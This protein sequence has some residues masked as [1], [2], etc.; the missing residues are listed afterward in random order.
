MKTIALLSLFLSQILISAA[1]SKTEVYIPV[2]VNLRESLS[3]TIQYV[4]P[5]FL[6]GMVYLNDGTSSNAFL[7]YNILLD[8]MHFIFKDESTGEDRILALANPQSINFVSFGKRLL[9]HDKKYGYLEVLMN[10]NIKLLKKRKLEV[11]STDQPKDSYGNLSEAAAT[12]TMTS[13]NGENFHYSPESEKLI[14]ANAIKIEKFYSLKSKIIKPIKSK[15]SLLK[16][17]SKKNKELNNFFDGLT[18]KWNEEQNLIEY[19]K[20]VNKLQ[21][22]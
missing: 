8:E 4:E 20:L 2:N 19:F 6:L 11:K 14:Q 18:G 12:S 22:D 17:G 13:F 1:Q 16:L 15:K 7:N 21:K 5:H 10:G 3:N 9:I